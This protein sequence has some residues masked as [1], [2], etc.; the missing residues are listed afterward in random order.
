MGIHHVKGSNCPWCGYFM[1]GAANNDLNL[2][3]PEEGDLTVCIECY[4]ECVFK[5]NNNGDLYLA[6]LC[7]KSNLDIQTISMLHV[8]K[9][10][11][12]EA[13]QEANKRAQ[14]KNT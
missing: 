14:S 4:G 6:P 10:R 7:D 5:T 9:F 8:T 3:C 11:L 13:K 12:M 1:D 2:V